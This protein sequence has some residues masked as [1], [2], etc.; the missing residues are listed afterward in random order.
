MAS[1]HLRTFLRVP[2]N[3][4]LLTGTVLVNN[5][6]LFGKPFSKKKDRKLKCGVCTTYDLGTFISGTL[7]NQG[8]GGRSRQAAD[9]K[10]FH[11]KLNSR[12]QGG[13][14]VWRGWELSSR[15]PK[16]NEIPHFKGGGMIKRF[17]IILNLR[18]LWFI[19]DLNIESTMR[20]IDQIQKFDML[21]HKNPEGE[22]PYGRYLEL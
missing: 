12:F 20:F 13:E 17:W 14:V 18:N 1:Q 16:T 21:F 5:L 22:G 7:S 8:K 3:K 6:I 10:K 4:E 15:F 2:V 11:E 9:K 19:I